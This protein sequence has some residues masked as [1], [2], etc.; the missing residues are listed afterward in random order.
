[1]VYLIDR[2]LSRIT[3]TCHCQLRYVSKSK[4]R[5]ATI[6]SVSSLT[7][8]DGANR[9]VTTAPDD[10]VFTALHGMQ[11]RSSDEKAVCLSVCQTRGL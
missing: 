6:V 4:L 7:F 2:H 10:M 9:R 11:T 5:D 8:V 3:L 1:V